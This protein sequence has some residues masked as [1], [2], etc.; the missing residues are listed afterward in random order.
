MLRKKPT[1]LIFYWLFIVVLIDVLV[2]LLN[3]DS[4]GAQVGL[5][6]IVHSIS[7][8]CMGVMIWCPL[9]FFINKVWFKKNWFLVL[10]IFS[11]SSF[12]LWGNT[13]RA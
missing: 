10:F 1:M 3:N 4:G 8:Y 2:V 11:F 9:T 7:W 12:L 13:Y 5:T 6:T